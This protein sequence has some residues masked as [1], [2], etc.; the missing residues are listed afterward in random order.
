MNIPFPWNPCIS[1]AA[2]A[3]VLSAMSY[4]EQASAERRPGPKTVPEALAVAIAAPDRSPVEGTS[5]F[6]IKDTPPADI[7]RERPSEVSAPPPAAV[8][9]T[10]TWEQIRLLMKMVR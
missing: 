8:E 4:I 7:R 1:S 10:D 9:L 2:I 6:R 3:I 5:S